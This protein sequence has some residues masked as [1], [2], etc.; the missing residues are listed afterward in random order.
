MMVKDEDICLHCGLCA[1]RCPTAAW[2]MRKF[3][4]VIAVCGRAR[5]GAGRGG[6]AVAH[7]SARRRR[8]HAGE[9]PRDD[10]HPT[11]SP[12]PAR[13]RLRLQDR[14]GQRHRLG[15]REQP[16]HAGDLPHGHPGHRQKRLPVEHPGAAHVVRD[17][18]QQRRLHGAHAGLRSRRR[19]EPGHLRE[20]HRRGPAGR[21]SA[22]RLVL[23]ARPRAACARAS[24]SSAFRLGRM[25]VETFQGDRERTLLQNIV[26]AGAL[27]ALLEIDMDVVGR[28]AEGEVLAQEGAARLELQAPSG[29]AT[30]TRSEHYDC[31]LPFHLERMDATQ[32]LRPARRQHRRRARLRLR[33]RDGRRLVSDHAVDV[34]DGG[35]QGILRALPRRPGDQ[36]AQVRASCRRRTSWRPPA[37]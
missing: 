30:T 17:P 28:D 37:W 1:E 19:A 8:G 18:G 29:S 36:A 33:G 11:R 32:R 7:G 23:A 13:Q 15:E 24:R 34:A 12:T 9:R 3:E 20:R 21:L 27:A 16:A 2:D 4:L 10:A 25:C 14:H 31:P 5:R 22:V 35:V 26:Y 6:H